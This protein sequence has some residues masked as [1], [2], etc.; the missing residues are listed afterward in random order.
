MGLKVKDV[1][2]G[3]VVVIQNNMISVGHVG[4][5]TIKE[6]EPYLDCPVQ[7]GDADFVTSKGDIGDIVGLTAL[8]N[9][10]Y[11]F[12]YDSPEIL[13]IMS[14]DEPNEGGL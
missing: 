11:F 5:G 8:A 10:V 13:I 4:S 3:F 14:A 7:S 9:T 6:I 12:F 1:M 2:E